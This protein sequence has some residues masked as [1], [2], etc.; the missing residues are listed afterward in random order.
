LLAVAL[1]NAIT[2]LDSERLVLGGGLLSRT[3]TLLHLT[4]V[5]MM[6]AAPAPILDRLDIVAAE[7]GDNAGMVGAAALAASGTS[8]VVL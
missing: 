6:A 7:L 2:I 5:A 4:E 1:G 8:I 3:P